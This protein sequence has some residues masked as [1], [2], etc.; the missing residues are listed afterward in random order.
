MDKIVYEKTRFILT[1]IA[2]LYSKRLNVK[3]SCVHEI[4]LEEID[5]DEYYLVNDNT[6]EKIFMFDQKFVSSSIK[7]YGCKDAKKMI[8]G[9][10]LGGFLNE[11]HKSRNESKNSRA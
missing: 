1:K 11:K 3:F 4:S 10:A 2:N 9:L 6:K 5:N 8:F 7:Y